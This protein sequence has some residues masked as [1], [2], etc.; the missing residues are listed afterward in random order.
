VPKG[1]KKGVTCRGKH[2]RCATLEDTS[3]GPSSK[4][5]DGA[6]DQGKKDASELVLAGGGQNQTP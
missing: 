5:I 1:N 6:D 4:Q 3:S 2:K